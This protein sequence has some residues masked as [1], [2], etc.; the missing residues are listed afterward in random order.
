MLFNKLKQEIFFMFSTQNYGV[1][2]HHDHNEHVLPVQ[3]L[4][5]G[6]A[7]NYFPISIPK[8]TYSA[9]KHVTLFGVHWKAQTVLVQL[10]HS[11]QLPQTNTDQKSDSPFPP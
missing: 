10:D 9:T 5:N 2:E 1:K 6:S 7:P 8:R 11:T 3:V 4:Y